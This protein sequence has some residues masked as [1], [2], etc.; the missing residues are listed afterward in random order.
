MPRQLEK[1]RM[2]RISKQSASL[3]FRIACFI[4][5]TVA[6]AAV[7]FVL[8]RPQQGLNAPGAV[9]LRIDMAGFE[10]GTLQ[11]KV[12]EPAKLRLINPDSQFHTDG[13]GR[14]LGLAILLV[15]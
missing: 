12:G 5:I 10:P 6:A 8:L 4:G 7:V 9:P 14:Q 3:R 11:A 1:R 13:G 15:T 2:Q